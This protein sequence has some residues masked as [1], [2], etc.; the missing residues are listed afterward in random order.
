MKKLKDK[1]FFENINEFLCNYLPRIQAKSNLTIISYRITL[2]LFLSYLCSTFAI[3]IFAIETTMLTNENIVRFLV[4]LE[5][6]RCNS[7]ATVN[8]RLQCI[9]TF[10][11]YLAEHQGNRNL[12]PALQKISDIHKHPSSKNQLHEFL[13][14]SQVRIVLE[15]PGTNSRTGIRDRM[16]LIM[17]YDTGCRAEELLSM[18]LGDFASSNKTEYVT[19]TGKNKKTE[20]RQSQRKQERN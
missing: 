17:L 7:I 8:I 13:S 19:I 6:S 16:I 2:N 20:T 1:A 3:D 11:R 4:W 18:R 14:K 10:M 9:R 12:I 15:S 5:V